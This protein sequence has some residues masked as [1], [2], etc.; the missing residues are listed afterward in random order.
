MPRIFTLDEARALLPGVQAHAAAVAAVRADLAELAL[1][2]QTGDPSPHGGVAELKAFEARLHEELS[3]FAAQGLELKGWAPLVL[4]FPA[5]LAGREVLLCW[6]E[7]EDALA[8]YHSPVT[9]FA[10]RRR[11]P[12][13]RTGG[14]GGG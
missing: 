6:L 1:A 7:G 10:G 8:W 14:L 2:V 9:G 4:D 13:E 5:V 12:A 3:W 11:L